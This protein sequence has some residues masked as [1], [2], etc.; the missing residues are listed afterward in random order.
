[1][2]AVPI[3]PNLPPVCGGGIA[4]ADL[5]HDGRLDLVMTGREVDSTFTSP[6]LENADRGLYRNH[7]YVLNYKHGYFVE[8]GFKLTGVTGSHR[9][10]L[11]APLDADGDGDI[12]L[13]SSGY[14][15]PMRSSGGSDINAD[16]Y[17]TALY[18]NTFG[19]FGLARHDQQPAEYPD[20]F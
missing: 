11:L 3:A 5:N 19:V 2:N 4:W 14:R 9:A 7:F 12:D 8:T 16:L 18:E 17:H 15:G 10:G 13:L 20:E 6:T 1:M